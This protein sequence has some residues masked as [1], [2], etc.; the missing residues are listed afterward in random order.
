MSGEG[1]RAVEL[2]QAQ[3]LDESALWSQNR[4]GD[5]L[6]TIRTELT[7]ATIAPN[8]SPAHQKCHCPI[9]LANQDNKKA[10]RGAG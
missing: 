9:L 6:V 3:I 7:G 4:I 8:F 5:D 2:R 1:R 10:P